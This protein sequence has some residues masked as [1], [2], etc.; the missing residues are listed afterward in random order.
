MT[1]EAPQALSLRLQ[2][3][4]GSQVHKKIM[5]VHCTFWCYLA[6]WRFYTAVCAI[7]NERRKLSLKVC[8]NKGNFNGEVRTGIEFLRMSKIKDF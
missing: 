4:V 5:R 3:N 2:I 8:W 1:M 7:E 6:N